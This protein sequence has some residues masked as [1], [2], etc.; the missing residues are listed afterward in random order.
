MSRDPGDATSSAFG[1]APGA[2]PAPGCPEREFAM[3]ADI[4]AA[5]RQPRVLL[6]AVRGLHTALWFA[7]EASFI[8][9]L[10]AGLTKRVGREVDVAAGVVAVETSVFALSGFRCPL[11]GVA[12]R[13]GADQASVTDIYLPRW[14]AHALP[15]MHVPLLLVA[16]FLY[17]RNRRATG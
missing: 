13:L 8:Y 7:I 14:F 17:V 12:R 1:L 5:D 16:G 15:A 10:F 3:R 4:G 2:E 9:V 6:T 11:T